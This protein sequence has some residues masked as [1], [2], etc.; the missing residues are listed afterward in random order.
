MAT[1]TNV[2]NG[3]WVLRGGYGDRYLTVISKGREAKFEMHC[4]LGPPEFVTNAGFPIEELNKI[5]GYL[6]TYVQVICPLM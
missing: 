5:F 6:T 1:F 4:P 3:N 2:G